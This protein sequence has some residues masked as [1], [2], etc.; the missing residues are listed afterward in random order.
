MN[1]TK[2]PTFFISHGG[3]PWPYI[4]DMKKQFAKTARELSQLPANLPCKPKAILVITGHWEE[5]EFTVSTAASPPMRYDYSGFPEHTYQIKYPAPGSPA[6]ASRVRELLGQAGISSK[7]NP[8]QGFDHGTFVPLF[9]MYPDANI[10]VVMLSLKSN[11]DPLEHIQAGEALKPL[12]DEGILIIGS[13]LTYHNMQGFGQVNATPVSEQF[14]Q[15]LN[16]AISE[17]NPV[18]RAEKLI[19]WE[20][21][22]VARLAHPREDHLIPL[23]VVVGAAGDDVGRRVFVDKVF[24]VAMASYRFGD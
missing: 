9:L 11:Y 6:L 1:N 23:M 15:Y 12:R 13:G 20:T 17:P 22:P 14:E 4:D 19:N 5:S 24:N 8:H 3:G 18:N 21:A 7:K 16:K 10:P 2:L